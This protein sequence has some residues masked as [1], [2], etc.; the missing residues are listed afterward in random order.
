M[1]LFPE[2]K[3]FRKFKALQKTAPDG[4]CRF[5]ATYRLL[6]RNLR[7]WIDL[8]VAQGRE[9]STRLKEVTLRRS[10][11]VLLFTWK[12]AFRLFLVPSLYLLN[13]YLPSSGPCQDLAVHPPTRQVGPARQS[14]PPKSPFLV[15]S[16]DG[17]R[18]C[19]DY[20]TGS[21]GPGTVSGRIQS[22]IAPTPGP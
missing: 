14:T 13:L 6:L 1:L 15:R 10:V 5:A 21:G 4:I 16:Y 3:R 20:R 22:G 11:G 12:R 2:G 7:I 19:L 17:T 18:K 8:I 9:L